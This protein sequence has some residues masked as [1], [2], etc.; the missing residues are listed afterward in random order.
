MAFST[1]GMLELR[2]EGGLETLRF[3]ADWEKQSGIFFRE[4]AF[5]GCLGGGIMV[6]QRL[7]YLLRGGIV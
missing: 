1:I 4:K 2:V 3:F 7:R 5:A 6:G